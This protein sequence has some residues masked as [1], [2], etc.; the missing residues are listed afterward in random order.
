MPSPVSGKLETQLDPTIWSWGLNKIVRN[1]IFKVLPGMFEVD[2]YS[3]V[4]RAHSFMRRR[5]LH[6]WWCVILYWPSIPKLTRTQEPPSYIAD[7]IVYPIECMIPALFSMNH[8]KYVSLWT[9]DLVTNH[10]NIINQSIVTKQYEIE[11][12]H[13]QMFA[14][15]DTYWPRLSC[16]R[17]IDKNV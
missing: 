5:S 3:Q 1:R 10:W 13:Q 12:S 11:K 8:R 14:S 2:W 4:V 6:L 7:S 9:R 15:R 16:G 17:W